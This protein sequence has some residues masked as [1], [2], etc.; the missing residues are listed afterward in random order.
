MNLFIAACLLLAAPPS[1]DD[2]GTVTIRAVGHVVLGVDWPPA[3]AMVPPDLGMTMADELAPVTSAADI[4]LGS[5]AAPMTS[6]D[7]LA[8]APDG[9]DIW[10][11]RQPPSLLPAL[12]KLGFDVMLAAN[13][14]ALDFGP[15]GHAETLAHL[16]ALG[17]GA[18]GHSG[19]VWR[20]TVRGTRVA[21]L[22][23]TQ[24]YAP[25]FQ[26]NRDHDAAVA[27]VRAADVDADIVIALVHG[28]GEGRDAL[29]VPRG[30]EYVGKEA[31]GK[32]V[33]LCRA[34]VDAG[35]DLVV[36]FGAH[37]PRAM[38]IHH[39]RLIAYAL[40]NFITYGPFDIQSP[41]HLSLVLSVTLD[42]HGEL[43]EAKIIPLR[44]RHPGVPHLD[45]EAWSVSWIRRYSRADFPESAPQIDPDGVITIPPRGAHAP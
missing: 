17:I 28:G 34:L 23:F 13:N 12:A 21:V 44:L 35:A 6:S 7:H 24:P 37:A 40:G 25:D 27:A 5:M 9:V 8:V 2:D 19:E 29:H 36:G 39:D 38:E 41:N 33:E 18:V 10:A 14:H 43:R 1:G 3:L 31:R 30:R 22:G 20:T 26:S 32:M 4:T 11:L 42:R 15:E 45:P 16:E